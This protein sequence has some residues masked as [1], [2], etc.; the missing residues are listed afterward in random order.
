MG[1]FALIRIFLEKYDGIINAHQVIAKDLSEAECHQ[2]AAD[3]GW[4]WCRENYIIV[5]MS[6]FEVQE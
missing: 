6:S 4:H 3:K 1:S 2:V 5:D